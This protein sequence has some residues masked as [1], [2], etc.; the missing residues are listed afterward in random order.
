MLF[1]MTPCVLEPSSSSLIC[2]SCF[3]DLCSFSSFL[4]P[5]HLGYN[6]SSFLKH[7]V[8]NWVQYFRWVKCKDSFIFQTLY[9]P[10]GRLISFFLQHQNIIDIYSSFV[11]CNPRSSADVVWY[12]QLH[13]SSQLSNLFFLRVTLY[14]Y[15]NSIFWHLFRSLL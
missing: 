13:P 10:A 15:M 6:T 11:Q 7:S 12:I 4:H 14:M 9:I 1:A 8:W 5:F 2:R 3:L